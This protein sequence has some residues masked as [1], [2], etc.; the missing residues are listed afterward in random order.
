MLENYA[1]LL[2]F[3]NLKENSCNLR[4]ELLQDA[5]IPNVIRV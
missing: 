4:Q 3:H 5:L 2:Q 1:L